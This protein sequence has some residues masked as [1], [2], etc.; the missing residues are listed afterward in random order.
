H[1]FTNDDLQILKQF[2]EQNT[3]PAFTDK[4]ELANR[5]HCSVYAIENWFQNR[6]ARLPP[7]ERQRI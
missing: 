4:N 7:R 6:R 5:I 2:F 1:R 3:Y